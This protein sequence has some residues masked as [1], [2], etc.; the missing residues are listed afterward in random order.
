MYIYVASHVTIFHPELASNLVHRIVSTQRCL[1]TIPE[2]VRAEEEEEE[3]EVVNLTVDVVAD[4]ALQLTLTKSSL[5]IFSEL[6]QVSG[7][8]E[9]LTLTAP[10]SGPKRHWVHLLPTS[11]GGGGDKIS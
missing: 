5:G 6:V 7:L 10:P 4:S 1:C 9:N 2:A 8:Y 11:W 3:E